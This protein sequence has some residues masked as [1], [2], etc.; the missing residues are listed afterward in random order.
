[1]TTTQRGATLLLLAVLW[2]GVPGCGGTPGAG[3]E[4]AP[5]AAS[6]DEHDPG[7]IELDAE[8]VARIGLTTSLRRRGRSIASVRRPVGSASTRTAWRTSARASAGGWRRFPASSAP[9]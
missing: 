2:I 8:A 3:G 9:T 5:A 4:T 1:M 6:E 7:I